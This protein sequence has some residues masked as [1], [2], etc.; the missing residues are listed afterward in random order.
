MSKL[1]EWPKWVAKMPP[2]FSQNWKEI[3]LFSFI[4]MNA[5]QTIFDRN[6]IAAAV[7]FWSIAY[8]CFHLPSSAMSICLLDGPLLLVM[9]KTKFGLWDFFYL[10]SKLGK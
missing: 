6:I 1:K 9:P 8:N 3:G 7:S 5:Y 4:L 10:G 2:F